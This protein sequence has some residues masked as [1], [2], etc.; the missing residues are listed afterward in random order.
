[1]RT[2]AQLDSLTSNLQTWSAQTAIDVSRTTLTILQQSTTERTYHTSESE[3]RIKNHP[4]ENNNC[5]EDPANPRTKGCKTEK[6]EKITK[7]IKPQENKI[8]TT[9]R[10]AIDQQNTPTQCEC[11]DEECT[12]IKCDQGIYT[13]DHKTDKPNESH[14]TGKPDIPTKGKANLQ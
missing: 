3:P 9:E 6:S 11:D 10:D 14:T 5:H 13:K 7:K 12:K 8:T 4:D 2:T 1:M